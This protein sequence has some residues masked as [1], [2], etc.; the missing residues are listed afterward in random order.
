[1][2][3]FEEHSLLGQLNQLVDW[4]QPTLW[5]AVACIV[6]NPLFWNFAARSEYRHRVI[7][8]L[9]GGSA[10]FG[11]YILA[12]TIF[13]LGIFRDAVYHMALEHQP[14]AEW[15]DYGEVKIVAAVLWAVGTVLVVSSMY[16]LGITGTYLGDYFGILMDEMVTGFP[17]NVT[18]NPMYYGSFL[19]FVSVALWQESVAGLLL[20]ALVLVAYLIA[21]RFEEPF[22]ASIYSKRDKAQ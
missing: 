7:T 12:V 13:G 11:C 15:L 6:F 9:A 21:L 18:G 1:M 20:S 10:Y 22:T 8:K 17:F 19:A 16:R 2:T 4:T 14:K 5:Q 3:L